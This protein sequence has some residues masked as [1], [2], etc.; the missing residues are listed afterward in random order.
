MNTHT[1]HDAAISDKIGH[2]TRQFLTK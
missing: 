1:T 2:M